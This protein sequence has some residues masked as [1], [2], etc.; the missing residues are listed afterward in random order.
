MILETDLKC[1][2]CTDVCADDYA[3]L[4]TIFCGCGARYALSKALIQEETAI[5]GYNWEEAKQFAEALVHVNMYPS[6]PEQIG[7]FMIQPEADNIIITTEAIVGGPV[8]F[9]ISK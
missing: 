5:L 9:T 4:R 6:V 8:M 3:T 7:I 2:Q 1:L